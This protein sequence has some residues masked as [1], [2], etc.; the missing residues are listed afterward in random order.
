MTRPPTNLL[1]MRGNYDPNHPTQP[2]P[3]TLWNR[4]RCRLHSHHLH[5]DYFS[6]AD[7]TVHL[8]CMRCSLILV[9]RWPRANLDQPDNVI[10]H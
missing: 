9:A 8:I 4:L 1:T 3:P 7:N 10:E 5:F 6:H 2:S